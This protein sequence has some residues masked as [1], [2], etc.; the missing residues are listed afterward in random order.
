MTDAALTPGEPRSAWLGIL[1]ILVGLIVAAWVAVGRFLFGIGGSMTPWYLLL[2]TAIFVGQCFA[3]RAIIL[4][5]RR[6]Y[7]SRAWTMVIVAFSWGFGL[8]CGATLPDNTPLG[9]QT[10]VSGTQPTGLGIAIGVTN[11]CAI[12]CLSLTGATIFLG[13][14]DARGRR[15][16][17]DEDAV[18]DERER[19]GLPPT[20]P[21]RA[22]WPVVRPPAERSA[23]DRPAADQ[24]RNGNSPS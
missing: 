15:P 23:A 9:M 22:Q 20:W 13:Y 6:G 12:V 8:L 21:N 24:E 11:P 17:Y 1:V 18:L 7:H 3:G 14:Y 16:K 4:T 5:A 10:I 2:G 19:L